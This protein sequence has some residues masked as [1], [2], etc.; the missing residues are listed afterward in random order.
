MPGSCFIFFL[1]GVVVLRIN[2][3]LTL[4]L[5][6]SVHA[7]RSCYALSAWAALLVENMSV[8][9]YRGTSTEDVLGRLDVCV[10]PYVFAFEWLPRLFSS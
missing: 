7:H 2:N 8:T 10:T 6:G 1:A 9:V 4:M 5:D 3:V